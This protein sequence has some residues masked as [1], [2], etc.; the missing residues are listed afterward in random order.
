[1]SGRQRNLRGEQK[2][3]GAPETDETD[4]ART[5]DQASE[6]ESPEPCEKAELESEQARR[7]QQAW[8]ARPN[9]RR[10]GNRRFVM[11]WRA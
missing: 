2:T 10:Q 4:E 8:T 11:N 6:M 5:R 7:L 9:G 1:M 3:A